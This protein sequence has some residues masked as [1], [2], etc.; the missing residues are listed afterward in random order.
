MFIILLFLILRI[1][2]LIKE[3]RCG[4]VL[5][6]Y[7]S[8]SLQIHPDI[9]PWKADEREIF[10]IFTM[11]FVMAENWIKFKGELQIFFCSSKQK[12]LASVYYILYL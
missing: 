7:Q 9:I 1:W 6:S 12:P 2:K 11:T 3:L 10:I 8:K 5:D 4:W